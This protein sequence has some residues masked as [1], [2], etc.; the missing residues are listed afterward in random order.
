MWNSPATSNNNE[1]QP[2]IEIPSETGISS[3]HQ[4]FWIGFGVSKIVFYMS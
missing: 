1:L 4:P 2:E 3:P